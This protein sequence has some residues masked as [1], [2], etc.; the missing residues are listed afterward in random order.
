MPGRI[1]APPAAT[2]ASTSMAKRWVSAVDSVAT[3]L[4]CVNT[5]ATIARIPTIDASTAVSFIGRS[6]RQT[7]GAPPSVRPMNRLYMIQRWSTTK[8]LTTPAKA[9]IARTIV[10]MMQASSTNVFRRNR[11]VEIS[12][13]PR[14]NCG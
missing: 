10:P 8:F 2:P 14:M 13:T 7:T 9:T 1:I 12:A 11:N 6:M 5:R 3:P 4:D